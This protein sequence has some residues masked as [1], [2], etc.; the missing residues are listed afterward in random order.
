MVELAEG[1]NHITCRCFTNLPF[2]HI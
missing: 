1:C 2:S